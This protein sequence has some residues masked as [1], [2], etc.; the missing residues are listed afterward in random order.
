ME[1]ENLWS[2]LHFD[3][4]LLHYYLNYLENKTNGHFASVEKI[5]KSR[6][7]NTLYVKQVL[8]QRDYHVTKE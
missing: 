7:I 5:S 6:R 1:K 3:W 4:T 8:D 2:V